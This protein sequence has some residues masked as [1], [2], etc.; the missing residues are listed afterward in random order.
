MAT[1]KETIK[2]SI[3]TKKRIAVIIDSPSYN[4]DR[5]RINAIKRAELKEQT[6]RDQNP[7]ERMVINIEWRKSRNW[8]NN[9]YL[10]AIVHHTNGRISRFTDTCSGCG[11]DKEST[12]IAECFNQFLKYR[13]YELA[14]TRKVKPYGI[15]LP[16]AFDPH[17]HGGIGTSCYTAI[18]K[19]IGGKFK[20]V[21]SGSTFDVYELVMKVKR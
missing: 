7:V 17:Y 5:K 9:P 19:F 12:V 1:L 2:Q 3:L 16:G 11:Y 15:S 20:H 10:N 18:A 6:E 8:G 13:L 21:S 14:K 4:T